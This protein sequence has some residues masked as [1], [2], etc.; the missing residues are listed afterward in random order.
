MVR[1]SKMFDHVI[2][3]YQFNVKMDHLK[4]HMKTATK[5][6]VST[7]LQI[8]CQRSDIQI[9]YGPQCF[10]HSELHCMPNIAY[11]VFF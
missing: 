1:K 10:H 2:K 7:N 4:R 8:S 3:L 5:N 11:Q 6:V 9:F